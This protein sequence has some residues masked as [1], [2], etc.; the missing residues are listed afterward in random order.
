MATMGVPLNPLQLVIRKIDNSIET[1]VEWDDIVWSEVK[2]IGLKSDGNVIG[3]HKD[4]GCITWYPLKPF[5]YDKPLFYIFQKAWGK[6]NDTWHRFYITKPGISKTPYHNLNND[7]EA[8]E[9]FM[10]Y[11]GTVDYNG[12]L[13]DVDVGIRAEPCLIFPS[14]KTKIK[15]PI[16]LQNCGIEYQFYLNPEWA[17]NA[18]Q[19]IKWLRVYSV[20]DTE[21]PENNVYTDYNIIQFMEITNV[22]ELPIYTFEFYNLDKSKCLGHFN[23]SDIF[24]N[25]QNRLIKIEEVTLPNSEVTYCIRVGCTFGVLNS[26]ETLDIDPIIGFDKEDADLWIT[27]SDDIDAVKGKPATSGTLD[28]IYAYVDGCG[29]SEKFIGVIYDADLNYIGETDESTG[30]N[31]WVEMEFSTKPSITAN[32]IYYIGFSV[33]SN[34]SINISRS[35]DDEADDNGGFYYVANYGYPT[36]PDLL[37][38]SYS[39]TDYCFNL[40]GSYTEG[41]GAA[42]ETTSPG[43]IHMATTSS[44]RKDHLGTTASGIEVRLNRN[45]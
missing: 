26:G 20:W 44:G 35:N 18:Q 31:G 42:S 37:E 19:N 1:G 29:A 38:W 39:S 13:F 15:T 23:F 33:D 7:I 14:L 28:S 9:R 2:E 3:F 12:N 6:V 25:S 34:D 16:N 4:W 45:T 36:F 32:T 17:G 24:D 8:D 41:G 40:Y 11:T 43:D 30:S 10:G 22:P 5:V 27:N 21:N